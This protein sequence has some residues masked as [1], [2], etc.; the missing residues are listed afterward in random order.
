VLILQLFYGKQNIPK[1][2]A[3]IFRREAPENFQAI[4][5]GIKTI[6]R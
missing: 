1:P 2:A 4:R 5:Q 3:K 6:E